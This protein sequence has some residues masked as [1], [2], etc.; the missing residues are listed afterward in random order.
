MCGLII[1]VKWPWVGCGPVGS[2]KNMKL[3]EVNIYSHI[4]TLQ[5][6]GY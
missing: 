5:L 1:N 6:I 4:E 3:I 2:T